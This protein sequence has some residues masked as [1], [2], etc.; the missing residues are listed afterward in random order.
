VIL[1]RLGLALE[2]QASL[3]VVVGK[4]LRALPADEGSGEGETMV[5]FATLARRN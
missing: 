3:A 5:D 1:L 2:E 4:R